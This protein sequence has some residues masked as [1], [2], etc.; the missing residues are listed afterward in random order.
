M[1]VEKGFFI[2]GGALTT[3]VMLINI[4]YYEISAE[5]S[6]AVMQYREFIRVNWLGNPRDSLFWMR[7]SLSYLHYEILIHS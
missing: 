5:D 1:R 2:N 6:V 3:I 7:D 4:G